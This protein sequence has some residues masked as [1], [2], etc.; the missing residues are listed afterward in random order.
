MEP[1]A[2]N[3]EFANGFA[4]FL[5]SGAHP[6]KTVEDVIQILDSY[7]KPKKNTLDDFTD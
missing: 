1:R 7:E 3:D 5:S 6:A 4:K 2:K